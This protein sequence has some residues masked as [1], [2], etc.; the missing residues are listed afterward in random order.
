M[1]SLEEAISE[2]Q[3]ELGVRQRCYDRWIQD[4]KLTLV[5]ARDRMERLQAAIKYLQSV[6]SSGDK[7]DTAPGV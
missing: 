3:R 4:G 1:R 2:C 6:T 5:D 7:T